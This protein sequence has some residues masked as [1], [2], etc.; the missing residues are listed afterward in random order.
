MA[1]P[2]AQFTNARLLIETAGARGGPETGYKRTPGQK[3]VVSLFLKQITGDK[4]RS[5]FNQIETASIATDFL[6]G[7]IVSHAVL[8]ENIDWEN[9]DLS[10]GTEDTTGLRPDAL[11]KGARAAAVKFGNRISETAEIIET[12]GAFDDAGIGAIVRG[13]LGDRLVLKVEWRQ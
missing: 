12:A 9:Y 13:V 2:L 7:Y 8:P 1:S 5:L 3:I 10:T 4:Q 11:Y 6:Q